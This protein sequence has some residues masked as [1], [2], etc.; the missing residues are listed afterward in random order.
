MIKHA[1]RSILVISASLLFACGGSGKSE[2][3]SSA[4]QTQAP[5]ARLS[6]SLSMSQPL[7][8]SDVATI[9]AGA[10]HTVGLKE[11]GTVVAVGDDSSGQLDVSSWANI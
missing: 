9:A 5:Q 3:P 7:Q 4:T 8:C 10:Y 1:M 2:K 11:D 6:V